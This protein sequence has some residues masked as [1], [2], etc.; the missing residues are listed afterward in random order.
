MSCGVLPDIQVLILKSISA[1][2]LADSLRKLG[3]SFIGMASIMQGRSLR[4]NPL[5]KGSEIVNCGS[6]VLDFSDIKSLFVFN[7]VLSAFARLQGELGMYNTANNLFVPLRGKSVRDPRPG[8]K[9]GMGFSPCYAWAIDLRNL[10][11]M[12]S[13]TTKARSCGCNSRV[14]HI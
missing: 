2:R 11:V 4:A 3:S 1:S 5:D 7:W 8:P 6:R 10:R 12:L 14:P 13:Q 9:S